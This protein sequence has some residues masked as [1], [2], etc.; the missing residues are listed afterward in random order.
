MAEYDGAPL[1]QAGVEREIMRLSNAME[2]ATEELAKYAD[3]AAVAEA[4]YKVG[5]A[6]AVLKA[7]MRTDGTGRGG[8][9]TEGDKEATAIVEVEQELRRRCVKDAHHQV[10]QEK[11]RTMRA[12]IDALRTV[13]ANIRAQT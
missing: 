1:T 4:D 3:E 13:S 8:R 6:K 12:R 2:E 5:Y 9:L 7:G 11:L 10:A